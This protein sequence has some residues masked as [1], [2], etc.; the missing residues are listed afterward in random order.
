[1]KISIIIAT[2]NSGKT[3]RQT[4]DSIRHQTYK[5][6]EVIVVDGKSTDNT[7]DIVKEYSDTV[8]KCIS[9]K[10]TG[11]YNAFNKGIYLAT[12]DYMCFIGSDDCY[13][14]YDVFR[15]VSSKLHEC[16]KMYSF[17]I[18]GINNDT[19]AENYYN[20]HCSNEAILSGC[21]IPHPGLITRADVMRQYGFDEDN[22]IISDYEFIV[23]YIVDGGEIVFCDTPIVYFSE[24]GTSGGEFGS[25]NWSRMLS[26]HII[27]LH[28]L[29]L[30]QYTVEHIKRIFPLDKINSISY[31]FR[32][33][34]RIIR[35]KLGV[36]DGYKKYFQF[37][38]RH[39]CKLNVC[40]W[41]GRR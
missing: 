23:R 13:C 4:L 12:G 16:K 10:D 21:M 38:K 11:I 33:I 29:G 40:R 19:L 26:E 28:K 8:T 32:F 41:C 2:F 24:D 15:L 39:K 27:M 6:L 1:M 36:S 18:I 3:L 22:K 30:E 35:R 5:E 34:R 31:H 14:N 20:N 9:E 25:N 7:L 17:P 37:W